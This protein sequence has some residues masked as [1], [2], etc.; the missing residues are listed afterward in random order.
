[1]FD[2][3]KSLLTVFQS[4]DNS[5]IGVDVGSAYLKVVQLRR[6][7][8]KAILETY[9]SLALGPYAGVEIGRATRLSV[10]K[11][12]EAMGD[13]LREANVTTKQA[14]FAIPFAS[15]LV[16]PIEMRVLDPK[17]LANAISIEARKYVPVPISE[18]SL[19]WWI[20]PD[21]PEKV[22]EK[23]IQVD[24]PEAEIV[25]STSQREITDEGSQ[26]LHILIAAIHNEAMN[27][28]QGIVKE[29]GLE[30]SFFEI[31]IFSTIRSL[32][33]QDLEPH[34]V[35]D[36]GAGETKLYVIDRG[37][38][39]LSHIINHGAQDITLSLSRALGI[40]VEDAEKLKREHGLLEGGREENATLT[41]LLNVVFSETNRALMNFEHK[42]GR[43]VKD[44]LLTGGGANL[45]GIETVAQESC[46]V[47]VLRAN[48]FTQVE[49]PAFLDD[50]LKGVG[51]E[52]TVAIGIAFRKLQEGA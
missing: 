45:K 18:V 43:K 39:K 48:P 4:P 27:R 11:I 35:L 2:W 46:S 3:F 20:I 14:A 19:D 16:T 5:V 34:A 21:E 33:T 23:T 9:G 47:P 13:L 42:F 37:L 1:M 30:S 6:K 49:A 32:F 31:E 25:S 7:G 12:A 17:E 38:M 15:S 28:Y 29:T 36:L 51:P 41:A 26:T 22:A 8:G 40:S 24:A 10:A 44:V 52:F 50:V